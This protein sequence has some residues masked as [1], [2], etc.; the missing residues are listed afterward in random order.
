ME[1]LW[2]CFQENLLRCLLRIQSFKVLST[3]RRSL[4]PVQQQKKLG[5]AKSGF[6]PVS[7]FPLLRISWALGSLFTCCLLLSNNQFPLIN[8]IF[9][10]FFSPLK[11]VFIEE[12]TAVNISSSCSV[13][14][15]LRSC[16]FLAPKIQ[17]SYEW[18]NFLVL[19]VW[20]LRNTE[21]ELHF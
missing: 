10:L 7:F 18:K 12:P 5:G 2:D 19:L 14:L 9:H 17:K 6:L 3:T 11:R 16:S 4:K 20:R 13:A 21:F 8:A 1:V 15:P